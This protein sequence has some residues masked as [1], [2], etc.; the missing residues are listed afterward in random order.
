[1]EAV[2]KFEPTSYRG[3]YSYEGMTGTFT[4]NERKE[5]TTINGVMPDVGTFEAY[6]GETELQ[7]NIH[8][9]SLQ[10]I[11]ELVATLEGAIAQ[12]QEDIEE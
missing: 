3:E 7:Y 2:T 5:L 8:P 4:A 10:N 1:M 12:V 11:T 9:Y 6:R